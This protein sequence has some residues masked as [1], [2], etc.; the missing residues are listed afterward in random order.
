M[1]RSSPRSP[2]ARL[3]RGAIVAGDRCGYGWDSGD[4]WPCRARRALTHPD[5]VTS[6]V[7]Q[8]NESSATPGGGAGP[9]RV[10]GVDALDAALAVLAVS[11]LTDQVEYLADRWI[12]LQFLDL[13]VALQRIQIPGRDGL[14][15][16]W[17]V[18]H[19]EDIGVLL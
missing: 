7:V 17:V 13:C 16:G 18:E 1:A 4:L 15:D 19:R 2:P 3:L 6:P 5:A 10:I 12:A 11:L 9:S 8:F 14:H